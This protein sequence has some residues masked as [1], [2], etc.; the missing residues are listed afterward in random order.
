MK[1]ITYYNTGDKQAAKRILK[2]IDSSMVQFTFQDYHNINR[3]I[4]EYNLTGPLTSRKKEL[5][6][7][8]INLLIDKTG[9]TLFR[10]F[11]KE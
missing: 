8:E 3:K 5:L 10:K 11:I 2:R 4:L 9:Y 6:K 1:A 7:E